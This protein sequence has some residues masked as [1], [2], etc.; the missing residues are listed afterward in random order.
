MVQ[1]NKVEFEC[2]RVE[3]I[4]IDEYQGNFL[5]MILF[6]VD[7]VSFNQKIKTMGVH[8]TMEGQADI[9]CKM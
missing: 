2:E 9:S 3:L 4:V 6:Q 1:D 8:E 5:P 7:K